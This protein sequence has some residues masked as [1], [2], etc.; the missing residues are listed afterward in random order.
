MCTVVD[1]FMSFATSFLLYF[2]ALNFPLTSQFNEEP[3]EG[4]GAPKITT[5]AKLKSDG[6]Q[7]Q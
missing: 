4:R 1:V 6:P 3:E 5:R 2:S 7:P